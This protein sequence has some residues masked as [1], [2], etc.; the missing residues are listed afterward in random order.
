MVYHGSKRLIPDR[1]R[2]LRRKSD[3]VKAAL[4]YLAVAAVAAALVSMLG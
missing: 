4:K 2:T 1:R 3:L